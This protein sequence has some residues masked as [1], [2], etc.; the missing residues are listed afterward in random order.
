MNR[1][2][3]KPPGLVRLRIGFQGRFG[4]WCQFFFMSEDKLAEIIEPT[5]WIIFKVYSSGGSDYIAV[6]GKK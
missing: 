4:E 2:R 3:G 1:R 5:G 6:V